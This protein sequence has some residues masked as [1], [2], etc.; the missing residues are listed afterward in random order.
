MMMMMMMILP[1]F[2]D[3]HPVPFIG[4]YP[5]PLPHPRVEAYS[6][7]K[8]LESLSSSVLQRKTSTGNELFASLGSA[9]V[10]TLG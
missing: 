10:Q 5:P 9:L 2:S 8:I 3:E 7:I 1:K 6:L 4:G